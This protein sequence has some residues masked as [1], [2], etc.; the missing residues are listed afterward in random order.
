MLLQGRPVSEA[1]TAQ[2][3]V[4][5]RDASMAA[6]RRASPGNTEGDWTNAMT[7]DYGDDDRDGVAGPAIG[8]IAV[9]LVTDNLGRLLPTPR[10]NPA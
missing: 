8:S 10:P 9:L 6:N 5:Q 3:V 1:A 7:R 2:G 4:P